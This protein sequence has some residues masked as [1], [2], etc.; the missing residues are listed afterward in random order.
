MPRDESFCWE[1]RNLTV[2]GG[3]LR[4][5]A[6]NRPLQSYSLAFQSGNTICCHPSRDI[7]QH[8]TCLTGEI[9]MTTKFFIPTHTATPQSP[10]RFLSLSLLLILILFSQTAFAQ[11]S[12]GNWDGAQKIKPGSKLKIKTKTGQKFSGKMMA[13]TADSITL[14]ATKA[15]GQDI[16]LK[17]E[18]IAEIRR[19]SGARTAGYAALLG[20]LGLASGYGIGYGVGEATDAEFAIEYPIAVFGAAIGAAVGAI[21]GSRGEVIYKAL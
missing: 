4:Q 12:K 19:K 21:I 15:S 16:K 10:D 11:S 13:V 2:V 14:S 3:F 8:P 5:S 18:E 1:L 7:I 20:G 17:R 6:A 9:D